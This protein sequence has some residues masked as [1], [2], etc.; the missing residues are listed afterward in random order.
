MD[1]HPERLYVVPQG[2][3]LDP[4]T[5][6][7]KR[8]VDFSDLSS[9]DYTLVLNNANGQYSPR[10]STFFAAG[11]TWWRMPITIQ[12]GYQGVPDTGHSLSGARHRVEAH[13]EKS[14]RQRRRRG[15]PGGDPGPGS[16]LAPHGAP[17]RAP[18]RRR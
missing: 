1:H 8:P 13:R 4:G 3:I 9:G 14:L 11:L 10:K 5:I 2:D 18:G 6:T 16:H 17:H 7:L 12:L 15:P